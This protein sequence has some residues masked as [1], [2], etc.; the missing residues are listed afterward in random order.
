MPESWLVSLLPF[1]PPA[2]FKKRQAEA[3]AQVKELFQ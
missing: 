1:Q 3:K 2:W